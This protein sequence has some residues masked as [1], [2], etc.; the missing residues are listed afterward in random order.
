MYGSLKIRAFILKACLSRFGMYEQCLDSISVLVGDF[1]L[2]LEVG[3]RR[4]ISYLMVSERNLE[5]NRSLHPTD[6]K[7]LSI[8]R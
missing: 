7:D 2:Q 5:Q 1:G 4:E 8:S 3:Q 6:R